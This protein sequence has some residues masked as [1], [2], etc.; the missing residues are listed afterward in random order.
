GCFGI[1][2]GQDDFLRNKHRFQI[3]VEAASF[4]SGELEL[5]EVRCGLVRVHFDHLSLEAGKRTAI[6]AWVVWNGSGHL[7]YVRLRSHKNLF[8]PVFAAVHA[9]PRSNYDLEASV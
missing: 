3:K 5:P 2:V 1:T 4:H 9:I 8:H 7:I 6:R